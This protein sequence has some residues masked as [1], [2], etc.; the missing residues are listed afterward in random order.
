M[1]E[2]DGI[3]RGVNEAINVIRD[4]KELATSGALLALF[5][6][7]EKSGE[8]NLSLPILIAGVIV[9]IYG[10]TLEYVE[11]TQEELDI[12]LADP[13]LSSPQELTLADF[14]EK[15]SSSS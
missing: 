2:P 9:G 7:L 3:H 12:Y 6:A 8:N 10:I 11:N 13:T 5:T 1:K 15:S 4:H 14:T